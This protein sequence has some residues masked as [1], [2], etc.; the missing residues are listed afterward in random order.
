[1]QCP[2]VVRPGVAET[3]RVA[4]L[5]TDERLQRIEARVIALKE[6]E[7]GEDEE[8]VR[9]LPP[10]AIFSSFEAF[11]RLGNLPEVPELV[12]EEEYLRRF[13]PDA[14]L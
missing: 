6:S 8:A 13:P 2:H 4:W 9:L 11:Q 5:P 14:A 7:D 10:A 12:D 1:V 3:Y